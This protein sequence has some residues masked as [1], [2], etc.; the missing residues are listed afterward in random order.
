V[1]KSRVLKVLTSPEEQEEE[2]EKEKKTTS[3]ISSRALIEPIATPVMD[4]RHS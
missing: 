2:E 3:D 4:D 1:S